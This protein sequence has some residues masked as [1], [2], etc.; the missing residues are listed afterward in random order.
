MKTNNSK[1]FLVL[2]LIL[3]VVFPAIAILQGNTT[4]FYIVY[5]YWWQEL[6]ATLLDAFYFK[7][8]GSIQ[9][10]RLTI[11]VRLFVLFIYFIFIVVIFGLMSNWGNSRLMGINLKVFLFKDWIFNINLIGIILNEWWFRYYNIDQQRD[12]QNPFSGRMI[13]MH[14]SIIFG[15]GVYLFVSNQ[16][17]NIFL[18]SNLWGSVLVVTPFLLLKAIMIRRDTKEMP[19]I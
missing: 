5:L 1:I 9:N 4:V 18:P 6:L 16:F 2:N 15:G 17:P 8:K 3:T 13:V 10:I 11:G 12:L 19:S 7:R 14:I